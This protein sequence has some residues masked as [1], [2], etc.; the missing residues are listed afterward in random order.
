MEAVASGSGYLETAN[1]TVVWRPIRLAYL[2]RRGSRTDLRDAISYASTEWGGFSHPIIA[3]DRRGRIEPLHLEIARMLKP[4]MLVNMAGASTEAVARVAGLIGAQPVLGRE[5]V[6]GLH[7][8][9]MESAESLRARTMIVPSRVGGLGEVVALGSIPAQQYQEWA[10][11][12]GSIAPVRRP[13]DLLDGQLSLP[14]PIGITRNGAVTVSHSAWF[15]APVIVDCW[16]MTFAKALWVWNLR[17]AA[18]PG[19]GAVLTRFLWLPERDLDEP[20]VQARLREACLLSVTDPDLILN[21]PNPEHLHEVAASI[22]MALM[23]GTN[24]TSRL[25][26]GRS[27]RD[28]GTRP[29]QYRVNGHPAIWLLGERRYGMASR[30][31]VPATKP[32]TVFRVDNPIRCRPRHGGYLRVSVEGIEQLRWPQRD[33]AARLI[34]PNA[35]YR[36]GALGFVITT[37]PSWTFNLAVPEPDEVATAIIADRGWHWSVSD[38]GQYAQGLAAAAG[39]Y[40]PTLGS[41]LTLRFAGA[42]TSLSR[43]KAE[44]LL[45]RLRASSADM[46]RFRVIER[47]LAR[48]QRWRTLGD[49]AGELSGPDERVGRNDLLPLAG[50]LL[51]AGLLVRAFAMTCRSCGLPWKVRLAG[52]D[53]I[54]RCPGCSRAQVLSGRGQ[55]EPVFS[56]ALNSLFDRALD[57]DCV[58][59]LLADLVMRRDHGVIW[60]VPGANLQ[61]PDGQQ[62]EVDLLAISRDKLCVAELKVRSADFRRGYVRDLAALAREINADVLVMGSLD[63]WEPAHRDRLAS[64]VGPAPA[65]LALGRSDLVRQDRFAG[66]A[67]A[68]I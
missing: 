52:A 40:L 30:L 57:Q 28:L 66:S 8:L 36:D 67:V 18:V 37:E 19:F 17:A 29:L 64:W 61:G 31:P 6:F 34:E 10:D 60:S 9:A 15:G 65:V 41:E 50:S 20:D 49:I 12:V 13:I 54:V 68:S 48:E 22:G 45:R 26:F 16:P 25:E 38:K 5:A 27:S 43:R 42:L 63:E 11:L 56:Y 14:S 46:D 47:V 7:P 33:P 44:Q 58:S 2:I 1:T 24:T 51:E 35:T 32:K 21:G 53:D 3:P 23:P 39:P 4:D 55:Q 62:R 59:H